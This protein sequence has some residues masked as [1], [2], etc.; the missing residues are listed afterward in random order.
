MLIASTAGLAISGGRAIC[1]LCPGSPQYLTSARMHCCLTI[2]NWNFLAELGRRGSCWGSKAGWGIGEGFL[3]WEFEGGWLRGK[4]IRIRRSFM[5][6]CF[7]FSGLRKV[8][9]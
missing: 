4:G 9:G 2:G 6:V 5:A 3:R 8:F 7:W 1:R